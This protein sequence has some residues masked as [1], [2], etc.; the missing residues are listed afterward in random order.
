MTLQRLISRLRTHFLLKNATTAFNDMGKMVQKVGQK[1]V[2]FCMDVMGMRDDVLALSIEEGGQYTEELVQKQTQHVLS[3]GFIKPSVRLAMRPLLKTPNLCDDDIF[4]CLKEIVMSEK[5]H[6]SLMESNNT[7]ATATAATATAATKSVR[8]APAA[9]AA[10]AAATAATAASTAAVVSELSLNKSELVLEEL[11][12]ISQTLGQLSHLPAEVQELK[13]NVYQQQQL[14]MY[15]SQPNPY[16]TPSNMN[17]G[18][19]TAGN[20]GGDGNAGNGG[21]G[22]GRGGRGRGVGR[23]GYQN[24]G[25]G[26]GGGNGNNGSGGRG[27]GGSGRGRGTNG[28]GRGGGQ[29]GRGDGLNRQ[30]MWTMRTCLN[31]GLEGPGNYWDHCFFCCG[32]GHKGYEC[33]EKNVEG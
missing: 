3:V 16:N 12:Q 18:N 7:S 27:G 8:A 2:N 5:E 4:D 20:D 19:V 23:G 30:V 11:Q 14:P 22:D 25:S 24:M 15:Q 9:T 21:N 1:E 10:A 13:R 32:Q 31:C 26:R 17:V 29:V 6:E 33:P 28:R